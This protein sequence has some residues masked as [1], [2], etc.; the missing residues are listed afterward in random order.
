MSRAVL[1]FA[2]FLTALPGFAQRP[3]NPALMEPQVAPAMDYAAVPDPLTFPA[4]TTMGASASLAFNSQGHLF[5]L[6]RGP[7]PIAEFDS[8]GKYIRSFGEGLFRRSHGFKIDRD[9]NLWAT[10]V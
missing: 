3:T 7:Q 5:V 10:D 8:S 9:G 6:N 1:V 4:G 2:L